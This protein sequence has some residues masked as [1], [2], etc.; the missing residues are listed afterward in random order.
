MEGMLG[1]CVLYCVFCSSLGSSVEGGSLSGHGSP[2]P[3]DSS[4]REA[5][6]DLE[7]SPWFGPVLL[8][9]FLVTDSCYLFWKPKV[10]CDQL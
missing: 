8:D 5:E 6:A 7:L 9:C 10:P 4:Y 3:T 1:Q 2:L